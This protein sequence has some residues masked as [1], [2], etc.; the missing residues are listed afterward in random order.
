VW[1]SGIVHSGYR[2]IGIGCHEHRT[3]ILHYEPVTLRP[4][5]RQAKIDYYREH[6]SEGKSDAAYGP[7]PAGSRRETTSGAA[8]HSRSRVAARAG[9]VVPGILPVPPVPA[10][11]PWGASL[12]V[13]MPHEVVAGGAVLVELNARNTGQLVWESS[14][15]WPRLNLSFHVRRANGEV[16]RFDGDRL[17]LPRSVEPGDAA[18]FLINFHAPSEPGDY[19][20]EWDFVSEGE[21]WFADCGNSTLKTM[22]RVVTG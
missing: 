2:V 10:A 19:I 9:R 18:V 15:A 21:C 16:V 12:N 20:I 22:L 8:E 11:P 5:E 3:A 17:A 6:G 1:H 14:A 4:D 7:M 13:T